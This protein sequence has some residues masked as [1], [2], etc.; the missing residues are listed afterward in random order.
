MHMRFLIGALALLLAPLAHAQAASSVVGPSTIVP[1]STQYSPATSQDNAYQIAPGVVVTSFYQ[2]APTQVPA[3]E[4]DTAQGTYTPDAYQGAQVPTY[5][6][7][8]GAMTLPR[9][10]TSVYQ[11]EAAAVPNGAPTMYNN[12]DYRFYMQQNGKQMSAQDFDTW[13]KAR[14]IRIAGGR[15]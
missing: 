10:Q 3:Y 1:P 7:N 2:G 15:R 5:T 6:N 4:P 13:M 12:A 14:G 8:T 11:T 9:S